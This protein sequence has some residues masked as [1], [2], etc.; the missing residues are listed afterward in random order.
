MNIIKHE[1]GYNCKYCKNIP[2]TVDYFLIKCPGVTDE[3]HQKLNKNN[4]DYNK[5]RL[6]VRK[7][8][9]KIAV[10]FKNEFNFTVQNILFPHIWQRRIHGCKNSNNW[11]RN[12]LYLRVQIL[13]AVVKLVYGT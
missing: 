12:G 6:I 7:R 9:R 11:T 3:M 10:F 2:E 5:R 13:K 8:L 4:V 1:K